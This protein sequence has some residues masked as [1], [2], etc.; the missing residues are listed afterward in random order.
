MLQLSRLLE[1][2]IISTNNNDLLSELN[3]IN[4]KSCIPDV[5]L[6]DLEL[7]FAIFFK[8][9]HELFL[10]NVEY[11]RQFIELDLDAINI[12]LGMYL[13]TNRNLPGLTYDDKKTMRT[14]LKESFDKKRN[15]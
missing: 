2:I 1:K 11:V 9:Y 13:N 5:N 12:Y 6:S 10:S 14:L 8:C 7:D 3:S 4:I 15:L